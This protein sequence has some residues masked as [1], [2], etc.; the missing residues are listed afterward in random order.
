MSNDLETARKNIARLT[1]KVAILESMLEDHSRH[2]YYEELR[3]SI[4]NAL[5]EASLK[6][7]DIDSFLSKTLDLLFSMETLRIEKKGAIFLFDHD[8]A[9]LVLHAHVN[10]PPQQLSSI[11]PR[12]AIP[13]LTEKNFGKDTI[14]YPF[15]PPSSFHKHHPDTQPHGHY[16]VPI[17]TSSRVYGIIVLYLDQDLPKNNEDISFINTVADICAGGL[18]RIFYSQKILDYQ[19]TLEQKVA[20]QTLELSREKERL[21]VT[22]RS[23]GDGV[24]TT[25]TSGNIVLLNKVA[26]QLTG[27]SSEEA[28]GK[29]LLEVFNIVNEQSGT[30]CDNPVKKIL[31]DGE[32]IGLS[33]Q[34]ILRSKDGVE[35]HI[36]D[37]GAPI[38]DMESKII[39]TVL[40]FRDITEQLIT[41]QE[42]HKVKKLESV[43]V[44]AGGIAH[45]FNNI[46]SAILGNIDISL[47]DADLN[48]NTRRIL[49]NAKKASVRAKGL[50]HQLLTFAKGGEPVKET[51]SV[52]DVIQ[53]SAQFVLHGGNVACN[54]TIPADLWLVDIDKSQISQVIQ[55]IVLNASQASPDGGQIQITCSNIASSANEKAHLPPATKYV[56]IKISDDGD[57]IPTEIADKI[58]DPYFSTKRKGSGLG[59]TITHSIVLQ[60]DG[61][62]TV[63]SKPGQGTTFTIYLLA[64]K[65]Q[66]I[67]PSASQEQKRVSKNDNSRILLMDDEEI[68]QNVVRDMLTTMGHEVILADNGKE[69]I[70][71]FQNATS[72]IDL[73]IMDLTIPGGMGGKEAV[74]RILTIAP[75]AKVIV[76]SGY[77]HDPVMANY[78]DYG[79][80]AAIS[81]PFQFQ[82]LHD[83]IHKVLNM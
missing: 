54:F 79:F 43:G 53:D 1:R 75:K 2:T 58:F 52:N 44:L 21:A 32:I 28:A 5:Q 8:D 64:S 26:E 46:L 34:T 15:Q 47:F 57:G 65:Q 6:Q 24:I 68:V 71:A 48:E 3:R 51:S 78:K 36:D 83:V 4:I 13:H 23:I 59:L 11:L 63:D 38:R 33:K 20:A 16:Y 76:S 27:W 72:G 19:E 41:E 25:D 62:I 70:K 40:V 35:R 12:H 22:L 17:K 30:P 80:C 74:Q 81:K 39:G 49:E 7:D 56:K 37:S 10:I 67:A 29:P 73:I 60:H 18:E 14:I 69:A 61:R 31:Q 42:L 55:N 82:E 9:N 77:S 50:T 66:K 45:D